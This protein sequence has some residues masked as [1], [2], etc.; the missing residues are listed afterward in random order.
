MALLLA[1]M[2]QT[3]SPPADTTETAAV[4][5]TALDMLENDLEDA[6][7]LQE[8]LEQAAYEKVRLQ[9][10]SAEA[11]RSIPGISE[12]T[13]QRMLAW[14]DGGGDLGGPESLLRAGLDERAVAA[15]LPFV[16][17]GRPEPRTRPRVRMHIVQRWQRRL[18]LGKGYREAPPSGYLGSPDAVQWRVGMR[19]GDHIAA[20]VTLDKDAGEP[21]QWRP[22][23]RQLGA[24]FVSFY[25]SV[26]QRGPFERIVAGNYTVQA[27]EGLVAGQGAAGL[28]SLRVASS[29]RILKPHASSREYAYFS[30]AAIQSRPLRGVSLTGFLS[31]VSLDARAD[32]SLNAWQPIYTGYHRT[33]TEYE[34]RKQARE[35]AAGGV[36]VLRRGSVYGG[37]LSIH[38]L[39]KLDAS[40]NTHALSVFGGWARSRWEGSF[41]WVPKQGHRSVTVSLNPI[42]NASVH[43]RTR[44]TRETGMHALRPHTRIGV[45]SRGENYDYAEWLAETRFRPFPSWTVTL[46]VRDRTRPLDPLPHARSRLVAG[47]VEYRRRNWLILHIRVRTQTFDVANQCRDR[48]LLLPCPAEEERQSLRIQVEYRHSAALRARTRLEIVRAEADEA[49]EKAEGVLLYQDFRWKPWRFMQLD[50]RYAVFDATDASAR[51]YMFE[52]DVLYGFGVPSFNGRGQRWYV[53]SRM[54]LSRRLTLQWKLGATRYEDVRS[55]GSGRDETPGNRVRE[56]KVLLQWRFGQVNSSRST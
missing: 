16:A 40:R 33:Q 12:R 18:D 30:G 4:I 43:I 25:L 29:D 47:V 45:N 17:F 13:V 46:Q 3:A 11:L 49:D 21:I 44:R 50:L 54:Q 36:A 39:Q 6:G 1:F 55:T 2:M 32:T 35:R 56:T 22:G 23:A 34:R 24:D 19:L 26:D 41:E 42:E 52:N 7:S 51:V 8:T 14:R 27:G 9:T 31:Q 38:T 15:L 28:S 5:E 10:A 37:A 48:R 20:G 53:L